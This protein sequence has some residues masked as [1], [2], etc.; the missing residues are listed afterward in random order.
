MIEGFEGYSYLDRL[1]ILGLTTLETRF[2]RADSIEVYWIF[3]SLDSSDSERYFVRD[4]GVTRG[5]LLQALKEEGRW[6]WTLEGPTV[7][8][9]PLW[10]ST[11]GTERVRS[12]TFWQPV[13]WTPMY[14]K[15]DSS[16]FFKVHINVLKHK[17]FEMF[18]YW[19]IRETL[20]TMAQLPK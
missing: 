11:L 10:R 8:S 17:S 19:N 4:V 13:F 7:P 5:H 3:N 9:R 14:P 12:G 18:M 6:I 15:L 1:R 16:V 20:S 2:V